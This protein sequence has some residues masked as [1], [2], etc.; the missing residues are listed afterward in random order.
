MTKEEILQRQRLLRYKCENSLLFY[1]RYIFKENNGGKFRV[2]PHVTKIIDI[3]ERVAAG[4]IKR[5]IINI[6]PRYYKTEVVIKIFVSWTMLLNPRAK[7]LHLSYSD[8]LALNNS[9]IT[10]NYIQS[11]AFQHLREMKMR[12]D[13]QGKQLWTNMEG[14]GMYATSTGGAITGF[15]AGILPDAEPNEDNPFKNF[16]GAI[17]IDDPNKPDDIDSD[18]KR[19]EVNERY[20]NT[21]RSRVNHRDVPIIVIQQRLHEEDLSGFL[22]DGGSDEEWAHLNMPVLDEN[23]IPLCPEKHT[24]EEIEQLRVSDRYTFSGQYMQQPSPDAGDILKR[25]WFEVIERAQLPLIKTWEMIIDGAYTKNTKNDP[26]GLLIYGK[27]RND[28]YFLAATDKHLE[29]PEL[30]KYIPRFVKSNRVDVSIIR[31]EPKASGITCDQ[32]IKKNTKLNSTQIKTKFAKVG[33]EERAKMA[34]PYCEAGRVFLVKG[35]W[36]E[37]FLSQIAMFPNG[38][39]DEYIDLTAYAVEQSLIISNRSKAY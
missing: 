31:I 25:E 17:L 12:Y 24:F 34:A 39:H 26:T 29:M 11:D 10:K 1:A 5:L 16:G 19:E 6:P 15:G 22:L 3:L 32:L 38:K 33:K 2:Y 30:L 14:G 23:N 35:S 27:H 4:E 9:S 7:F 28:V 37:G 36:N 18:V 21:I 13:E 8:K 20:N